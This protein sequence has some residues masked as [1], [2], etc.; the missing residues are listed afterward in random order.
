MAFSLNLGI[1]K[2]KEINDVKYI[3]RMDSDDISL[4]IRLETQYNF[5]EVNPHIDLVGCSV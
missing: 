5:M 4:P 2:A 3:A 1:S